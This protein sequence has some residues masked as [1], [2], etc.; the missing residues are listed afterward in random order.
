MRKLRILFNNEFSQLNTGFSN[1]GNEVMKRLYATGKYDIAEMAS[2]CP[3]NHPQ[4]LDVPW[5]VYPVAPDGKNPEYTAKYNS[6]KEAQFG[7]LMI[8]DVSLDF[9][10]DVVVLLRDYWFDAYNIVAPYRHLYKL[11][12][13]ACMDS[14][15]QKATWLNYLR[16][17][18]YVT[19]YTEWSK[20]VLE[21]HGVKVWGVTP[22][23]T[24]T[25]QFVPRNKR[26][27]KERLGLNPDWI[28]FQTV[29]RN[30]GRKL[31][32]DLF[33][34]FAR[35]LEICDKEG[36]KTLA[37]NTYLHIH[38]S[39]TDVGF[40]LAEELQKYKISH[41][42]LVSYSDK[43][44][45][46]YEISFYKGIKAFTNHSKS[47]TAYTP[48]TSEGLT[49]DQMAEMMSI[50]DLYIQYSVA[51]AAEMPI[52]DAKA[53][54]VPILAT[55]YAGMAEQT[56]NGG[57]MPIDISC[58]VQESQ[59]T[60]TGQLRA[61]PDFEH[62]AWQM[63]KFAIK[64]DEEKKTLGEQAR[65]LALRYDWDNIS[66]KWEKLFDSIPIEESKWNSPPFIY[67]PKLVSNEI[68]QSMTDKQFVDYC[69]NNI[70]GRPWMHTL[71]I[72]QKILTALLMG[73][74]TRETLLQ[75]FIN[76]CNELNQLELVRANYSKKK[77]SKPSLVVI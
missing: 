3:S 18:D 77:E 7:S 13:M 9:K 55:A 25:K 33:K 53:C 67:Q 66:Q 45:K 74:E 52:M 15:P 65:N 69:Y 17:C 72:N 38:T 5:K 57:G 1:I 47:D 68:L 12:W 49:R 37:Q 4:I 62:A 44:T 41:K 59:I 58:Y 35:Y 54:G 42:V 21:D 43:L 46:N 22:P 11:V 2:Y 71:E 27:I 6:V 8:N 75:K 34:A 48:N 70:L 14:E 64:S 32:P 73:G 24:D 16:S 61:R 23:G 30:Q 60:E 26:E 56:V 19:T 39:F 63:F 28:V 50:A 36:K 51:G 31:Y 29:M 40:D 10:P 20:N 76:Y